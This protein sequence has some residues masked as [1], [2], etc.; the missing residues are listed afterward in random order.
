MPRFS[1]ILLNGGGQLFE[2][3][4]RVLQLLSSCQIRVLHR[5][6]TINVERKTVFFDPLTITSTRLH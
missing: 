4:C 2:Y 1:S 5:T 6:V 3:C